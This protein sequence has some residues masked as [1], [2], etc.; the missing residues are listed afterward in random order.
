MAVYIVCVVAVFCEPE[1]QNMCFCM[2]VN[3]VLRPGSINSNIYCVFACAA[4]V[5][6]EPAE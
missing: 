4:A 6:C 2:F 3:C 5:L 1:Q